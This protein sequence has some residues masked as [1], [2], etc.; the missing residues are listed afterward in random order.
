MAELRAQI[1]TLQGMLQKREQQDSQ[2]REPTTYHPFSSRISRQGM[3]G[4]IADENPQPGIDQYESS[5]VKNLSKDQ[6]KSPGQPDKTKN[7]H[8]KPAI[9]QSASSTVP[10][11]SQLKQQDKIESGQNREF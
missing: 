11:H 5:L 7:D 4:N 9:N 1:A 2:I 8:K 6:L 10:P 3:K